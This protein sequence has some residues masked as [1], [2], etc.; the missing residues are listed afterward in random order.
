MTEVNEMLAPVRARRAQYARLFAYGTMVA[1]QDWR[2]G[3]L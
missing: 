1:G 3:I 2:N